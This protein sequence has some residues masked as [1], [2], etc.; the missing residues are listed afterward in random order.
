VFEESGR[1]EE[2]RQ[3]VEKIVKTRLRNAFTKEKFTRVETEDADK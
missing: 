3:M 2:D 1:L